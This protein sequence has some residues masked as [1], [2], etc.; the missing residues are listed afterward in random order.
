MFISRSNLVRISVLVI[1]FCVLFGADQSVFAQYV[2]QFGGA[3]GVLNASI[4]PSDP[5]QSFRVN[6]DGIASSCTGGAPTAAAI[7][8][9]YHYDAYNF[10]NPTGQEVCVSV[11]YDFTGCGTNSTQINAYSTFDPTNAGLNVIGKPGFSTTGK[12]SLQFR[13]AAGANF[14]LVVHEVVANAGCAAYSYNLSYRTNCR[15]PG[16]DR[17]NDGKAD[18]TIFRPATSDW[19]ILNSAGGFSIE[20]FGLA[21][22]VLTPGDYTGDGQTDVSVYRPSTNFWYY[23]NNHTS[24]GTNFTSVKWG[25]AGDVP[26]PGDFDKDGKTDI[27][28]WRPSNGTWYTLRSSN[29]TLQ[30][31][32]W[33][34]LGDTPI[35]GDFDGDL[36]TDLAV[37]RPIGGMYRWYI[38]QS[39]FQNGFVYGCGTTAPICDN[40]GITWGLTTDKIVS[41][42][43]DG[44]ARTDIAVFRPST[45]DWYYLKSSA[46]TVGNTVGTGAFTGQH[47]GTAGDNPQPADYD[48]DKK[49]DLAV[50][51]PNADP[52]QNFWYVLR[53]SDSTLS[54]FEWGQSGDVPTTA[55]YAP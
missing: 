50:F 37:V 34:A 35:S 29:N 2:C 3:Q 53:S 25:V 5:T 45:G 28:V 12:A 15:E 20:N 30:V 8:G 44:D 10:T 27:T 13:V 55:P 1:T 54:V 18:P 11:D 17:T 52:Q 39:N 51:R 33:G 14:T 42:D 47:F 49:T 26:V 22:D 31:N 23:G 32:Q 48:G 38:L 40:G 4:T 21:N 16:F 46:T 7:A 43:F 19:Y 41:G 6:R 36:T 24:P 9:T